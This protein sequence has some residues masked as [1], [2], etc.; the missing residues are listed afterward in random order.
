MKLSFPVCRKSWVAVLTVAV[1]LGGCSSQ[2]IIR[3]PAK[4]TAIRHVQIRPKRVW[5]RN[6]GNGSGGLY[7]A[8]RVA[9]NKDGVFVGSE[10]GD[11]VAYGP[12]TGKVLWRHHIKGKLIAGPTVNG[13]AVLFGT[14]GAHVIALRRS[15][16]SLLWRSNAPSV[17]MAPPVS[18]DGI[19]VV[20]GVN[21]VI[22]GL[23]ASNGKRIWSFQ[24]TEP[25][26]TLRGQSAPLFVGG[27]VL[28]G[29][30]NGKI[31]ALNIHNGKL[32]WSDALA[33]PNGKSELRRLVDIDAD[34]LPSKNGVFVVSYGGDLAL[35]DPEN[36][37]VR[38]KRHLKSYTGMSVDRSGKVIYLTDA[39]GYV[40]AL[41]AANGAEKWE[42]KALKFRQPSAPVFYKS[43]VVVGDFKGYLHW[44]NPADGK[45]VGR[46]RMG[47]APIVTPPAI[48]HGLLFVMNT[49]GRLVAFRGQPVH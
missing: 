2:G 37:A 18:H 31:I 26:L 47:E 48:G 15:N 10:N 49:A 24:S 41:N 45:I 22:Y 33:V 20:R 9:V 28:I 38:W 11:A 29:L 12:E 39:K 27:R 6:I 43:Y 25:R 32:L 35:V 3:K 14:L 46:T 30:D 21:G 42:S 8:F 13:D 7:P 34:L 23:D 36:G 17:V 1:L 19:V 4:L 5:S 44:F 16:G 40:W